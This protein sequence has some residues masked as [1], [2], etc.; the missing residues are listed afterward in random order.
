MALISSSI[1]LSI[2]IS[3]ATKLQIQDGH[4]TRLGQGYLSIKIKFRH[5]KILIENKGM[6]WKSRP[7]KILNYPTLLRYFKI[8]FCFG[9]SWFKTFS[10]RVSDCFT[11]FTSADFLA[12]VDL[13]LVLILPFVPLGFLV[14]SVG[15]GL[16]LGLDFD[17]ILK[18]ICNWL[19]FP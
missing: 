2:Q 16:E 1:S 11:A 4:V 17:S 5:S 6:K 3:R 19:N 7:P 9:P 14:N 8:L 10:P 13:E 12:L 15:S 18:W